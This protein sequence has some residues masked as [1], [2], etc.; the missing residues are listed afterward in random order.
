MDCEVIYVEKMDENNNPVFKVVDTFTC[1][2]HE[3]AAM[4]IEGYNENHDDRTYY[5]RLVNKYYVLN[6][7]GTK[8]EIINHDGYSDVD[9]LMRSLTCGLKKKWRI[10]RKDKSN[11]DTRSIVRRIGRIRKFMNNPIVKKSIEFWI[12]CKDNLEWYCWDKWAT[13]FNDWK[14]ERRRIKYFKKHHHDLQE[15][16]SLDTHL[17]SDLKWNLI[18][19]KNESYG[20][21]TKFIEEAMN[22][23]HSSEPDWD[24]DKWYEKNQ[25]NSEAEELAIKKMNEV[26]DRII[27]LIDLYGFYSFTDIDDEQ[28]PDKKDPAEPIIKAGTYDM[29]DYSK[30]HEKAEECY[31]EIWELIKKYGRC[32]WD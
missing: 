17:L 30:M 16:W 13:K 26:Y 18:R 21:P 24:F 8:S 25:C 2:T 15:L 5:Y 14:H 23:A 9:N 28:F 20:I 19:L 11:S 31:F 3:E 1:E 32:M 4:R 6:S 10:A 7:D 12:W 29:V 22:E 27:N